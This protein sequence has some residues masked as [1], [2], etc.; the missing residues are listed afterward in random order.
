ML[1]NHFVCAC[2]CARAHVCVCNGITTMIS[3]SETSINTLVKNTLNVGSP[4]LYIL[5][6]DCFFRLPAEY[7]NSLS[8]LCFQHHFRSIPFF[9]NS[10]KNT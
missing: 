3:G 2:A 10:N 6:A 7:E 9:G 4:T 8:I 5:G 1:S